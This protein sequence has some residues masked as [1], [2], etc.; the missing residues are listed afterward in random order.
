MKLTLLEI[1]Q[2]ILSAMGSDEVSNYD[3]TVESYQI[4][5]LIK[6]AFYDCAVELGLPEH[7]SLFQLTAS[8]DSAKPCLMTVP[9]S[10][11]RLDQIL[12][13][14]KASGDTTSDYK[15]VIWMDFDDFVRMQQG[16]DGESLSYV[17]EQIVSNNGQSFNIKYRK[18]QFP[19]YYTSPDNL[20]L[21]F[22]GYESTIDTTL[23]QAKTMCYGAV[24]PTFTLSNA[25]VP[26][27]DATQFPYL[28][29]KAK[30]R[31]FMELKQQ[32]NQESAAEARKQKIIVQKRQHKINKGPA[33]HHDVFRSGRK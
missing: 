15:E 2:H 28:I 9:S 4:A 33:L 12:Y 27:L 17:G 26:D 29:A 23:T 31:A 10:V 18:D 21:I 16:L 13:D 20:T 6:Q 14:N 5:L 30:T 25:A 1:V 32:T 24:Y 19:T 8:G 7:D 11:T 22:D 3:D